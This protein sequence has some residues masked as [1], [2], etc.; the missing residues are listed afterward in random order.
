M[1]KRMRGIAL[2]MLFLGTC[3]IDPGTDTNLRLGLA[4]VRAAVFLVAWLAIWKGD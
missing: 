3:L 2:A 1:V 4:F